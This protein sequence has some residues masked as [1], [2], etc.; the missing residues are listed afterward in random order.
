MY[1]VVFICVWK[2][3][4][5]SAGLRTS[6]DEIP[7]VIDYDI[8]ASAFHIQRLIQRELLFIYEVYL[9]ESICLEGLALRFVFSCSRYSFPKG[10]V[11]ISRTA[12]Q[13]QETRRLQKSNDPFA[14]AAC[15]RK[16]IWNDAKTMELTKPV[17]R[18][19]DIATH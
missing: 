13:M 14:T 3:P 1:I 19:L 11:C 9:S 10:I 6:D 2:P 12:G 16:Y 4:K 15:S 17:C 18:S 5:P 7:A 8:S